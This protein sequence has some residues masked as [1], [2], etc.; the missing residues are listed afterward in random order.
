M[1]GALYLI[2]QEVLEPDSPAADAVV[3]VNGDLYLLRNVGFSQPFYCMHP[4]AH[5]RRGEVRAFLKVFYNGVAGLADRE[6]YTWWE[7]YFHAS[8]HKTH[9]EGWWLQQTRWMLWLEEG[10]TL[11]LLAGVP[12]AWLE[13]G[14]V[15]E[16]RDGASYFGKVSLRV[17]SELEQGRIRARV[18]CLGDRK[19]ARVT[20][21][22]PHPHGLRAMRVSGGEYD[23]ASATVTIEPWEGEAEVVLE[24][25]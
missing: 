4:Y 10:D 23:P 5:L 8:P 1:I 2:L 19:P 17:E 25:G 20:V 12:R 24:F 16:V 18:E 3:E 6:T 22:L 15:I 11:R 14:K 7:H 21:R 13:A 9:E